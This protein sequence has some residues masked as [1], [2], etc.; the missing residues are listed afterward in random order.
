MKLSRT[1]ANDLI[2]K[3]NIGS[4]V[5]YKKTA[6]GV[7][8]H[9]WI[10]KTDKGKFI[11]RGV[12]KDRKLNELLFEL[13]ILKELS[14]RGFPHEV[15]NP[16]AAKNGKL[17]VKFN[18]IIFWIYNFIEGKTCVKQD[19]N[20][21]KQ[22]A[23]MMALSH[24]FL[25]GFKPKSKKNWPG[26]F[27]VDWL[28][29]EIEN[30][31][32][33]AG[34]T[35]TDKD[36]LDNAENVLNSLKSLNSKGYDKLQKLPIHHDINGENMIFKNDKLVG[37]IDF[38][39]SRIDTKIR[40]LTIYLQFECRTGKKYSLDLNKAKLFLQEYRKHNKLDKKEIKFI[41]EIAIS[42]YSDAFWY[43]YWLLKNDPK[44]TKVSRLNFYAKSINWYYN[45][46]DKIIKTLG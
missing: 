28:I 27:E 21:I 20:K 4:L 11:L 23:K 36:F 22:T 41:P 25:E 30:S 29:K 35:K 15:P 10:L 14:E 8:N 1:Q 31:I 16:I 44:R 40:D 24:K 37:L 3:W 46:K 43:T 26:P 5:S 9:N 34:R 12:A 7:A 19:R 33:Q 45:N 17:F 42:E 6:E 2:S 38:D 13:E 18:G 32:K 39:D